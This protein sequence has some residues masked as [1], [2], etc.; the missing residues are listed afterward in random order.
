MPE[1]EEQAKVVPLVGP[2]MVD[3]FAIA[4]E[5]KRMVRGT[6][7]C[8]TFVLVNCRR[9]SVTLT[10]LFAARSRDTSLEER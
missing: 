3:F 8:S 2:R 4:R 1:K 6:D 9:A 7:C 10:A 5:K